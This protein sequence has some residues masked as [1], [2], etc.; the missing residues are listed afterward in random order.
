[1]NYAL[2]ILVLTAA[3]GL[4]W[5]ADVVARRMRVRRGDTEPLPGGWRWL[6]ETCRGFFPLL[7]A[8]FL[9]RSFVVEPF[10]IPS[11]S[12]LP[13]VQIGDFVATEK[14][15]YALNVPIAEKKIVATGKVHRGDIIVF[16]YPPHPDTD[17]IKRVIGLPGDTITYTQDN[18]LIINGTEVPRQSAGVYPGEGAGKPG[19]GEQLWIESLPREDGTV[20]KHKILL[21][22]GRPTLYGT[23]VVP[24]GEY[25][26]MGDNRDDSD[27]S[28]YW[29][30]VPAGN[31]VGRA[32]LVFFNFQ[33]W[34]H[35]PLWGRI[36][37][38]L[39]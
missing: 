7:L 18:R 28:R 20:V 8:V 36:G 39:H 14:F 26:M 1:V 24:S 19:E 10:H 12:M 16:R 22:P 33:G 9:L 37:T 15:A 31:L 17:F 23:W 30:D 29:G 32:R 35:W 3:T 25:F 2:L 34:T 13:T 11:G 4:I 21:I 27:D 6:A 5:L 38:L